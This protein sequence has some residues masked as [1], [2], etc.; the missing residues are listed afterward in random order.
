MVYYRIMNIVQAISKTTVIFTEVIGFV[1]VV[2][3]RGSGS[4]FTC[5][6]VHI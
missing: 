3:E 6:Q 1:M 5:M 4:A 2:S